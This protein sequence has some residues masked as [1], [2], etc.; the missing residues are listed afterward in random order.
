MG[1]FSKFRK[2]ATPSDRPRAAAADGE[3][4]EVR[5]ARVRTRRRLIGAVLLLGLGL[6]AFPLI[7]E[8]QPR[9][10]PVDVVLDIPDAAKAPPLVL[11]LP[12]ASTP[13]AASTPAVASP[14]P[15][16]PVEARPRP[17]ASSPAV[18]PVTPPSQSQSQSQSQSPRPAD[19]VVSSTDART[20]PRPATPPPEA[21]PQPKPDA[22]AAGDSS[23]FVVQVSAFAEADGA[24]TARRK[25]EAMGLKTYT[26]EVSTA[27]GKRIRVRV[28]PYTSRSDAQKAADRIKAGGLP[29]AVLTL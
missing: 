28:G 3:L 26:Q 23:R 5:E 6:V 11:P 4:R 20:P 12:R 7:F 16:P 24:R 15:T 8:T 18:T 9:P 2:D 10:V 19:T 17:T 14:P 21:K 13:S 29:A 22:D 1:L 27:G 25:V